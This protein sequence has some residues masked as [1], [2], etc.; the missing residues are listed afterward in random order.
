MRR[1]A[2]IRSNVVAFVIVFVSALA[3]H[4]LADERHDDA[5][6][7]FDEGVRLFELGDFEGARALFL[8]AEAARHSSATLFNLARAEEKLQNVQAAV[9]A[10]EAYLVEA[11]ARTDLGLAASVAVAELKARSSRL[12]VESQPPSAH[13]EIDG[14]TDKGLTPTLI[15][16]RPGVHRVRVWDARREQVRVVQADAPQVET[17]IQVDL[18]PAAAPTAADAA[19]ND[20]GQAPAGFGFV[21]LSGA[22]VTYHFF[23]EP[24]SP[25]ATNF[26]D[27]TNVTVGVA[28]DG[29]IRFTSR[30]FA[31]GDAFAAVGTYGYPNYVVGGSVGVAY[32]ADAGW[33]L[34]AAATVA[35]VDSNKDGRVLG[36]GVVLGPSVD[37]AYELSRDAAGAWLV[38]VGVSYLPADAR[39]DNDAV[40]FPA[41]LTYRF[42]RL[43][44]R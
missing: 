3:S 29:G 26:A 38:G 44:A 10:Y 8:R 36:S 12:R 37:V 7:A 33:W 34:R 39:R 1:H 24:K 35:A 15:Y 4:G 16:V 25:A 18:M 23:G 40:F 14:R 28:A 13:V 32:R 11:G 21:G 42:G 27:H 5:R 22:I 6:R 31:T 9:L 2:M 43:G 17:L 19:R 41:R 30:L 20:A